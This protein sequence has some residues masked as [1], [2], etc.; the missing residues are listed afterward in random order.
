M[1]PQVNL[2]RHAEEVPSNEDLD[3]EIFLLEREILR[4]LEETADLH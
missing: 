2:V 3:K 1:V 4:E